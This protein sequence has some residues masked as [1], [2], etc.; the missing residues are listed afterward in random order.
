MKSGREIALVVGAACVMTCA[1]AGCTQD[2]VRDGSVKRPLASDAV[3]GGSPTL[4][5]GDC[6]GLP[7][8]PDS[9][10]VDLEPPTFSDPL[11]V[12]NP[13]FPV[14]SL[15]RSVFHGE[16]DGEPFRSET[17]LMSGTKTIMLDGKPV[18][19]LISQYV[20]WIDRRLDE[21]AIDW[22]G[23][24]DEG[25]AYYFGENVYNYVDG[26]VVDTNG[27]W[28]AGQEGPVAMIMPADPQ[29]G[30][31]WRPENACPIVFE[32]VIAQETGITVEGPSGP[33]H[34]ALLVQE[35][36]MDGTYER[37]LFAPG[38]GEFS[39]GV[40]PNVETIAVS[41]PADF[42]GGEIPESLD[43]LS[44]R[45]E[46]LFTFARRGNWR[47]VQ[48]IA[49]AMSADW[50]LYRASGVPAVI[51]ATMD[52]AFESL[53]EALAGHDR[54]AVRQSAVDIALACVDF[55]VQY[56]ERPEVDLNLVEVWSRQ[57]QLDMQARDRGAVRGDLE[58]IRIIRDRL[59]ASTISALATTAR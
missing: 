34:G 58:T 47:R 38:Y 22:Y 52:T 13:L 45:A 21:V 3:G 56:E 5:G 20:A 26:V 1:L 57:L 50:E 51:A 15:A 11:N 29:V 31:V 7:L 59:A 18:R 17:T 4:T 55:E 27:T 46:A 24:D 2:S 19:T 43:D 32:E 53:E 44:N 42:I 54:T 10:R 25:N 28:L 49:G 6:L 40:A 12:T 16:S 39:T 9:L 36:H 23:Q 41:A 30:N 8:A 14:A 37:K 48:S 35:L 33:V